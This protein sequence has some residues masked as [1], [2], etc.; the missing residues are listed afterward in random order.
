MQ[1]P[2]PDPDTLF[3]EILQDLPPETERMAREFKAFTRT[4]KIKTPA[5]LLR[6][7]LLY[8]GLDKSL[9]EVAGN[10]TLL[11]ER[12]TDS[13]VAE[14]LAACRPWLKALLPRMLDRPD[15]SSLPEGQRFLV[16]DGS[17]IQ[18]P[19][20]QGTQ[21]HLHL[22]MDL[23]TLEFTHI[24]ITDKRTGE[25]LKNFP[26]GP[27]DVGVADRGYA[28]P[29]AIVE[30]VSAGADLIVRLNPHSV[31]LFHRDG[32]PLDLV[33][34]LKDQ[35]HATVCTLPV[36]VGPSSSLD[37]V[38]G[39]VHAYRLSEEQANKARQACRKRNKRGEARR[40]PPCFWPVGF[41]CLPPFLQNSS[42][43]RQ[44]WMC[45]V[46]GGR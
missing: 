36:L 46:S 41:W 35:L 31:P 17:C 11:E 40:R 21:Y 10:L 1:S 23:V 32:S 43:R 27:G 5:Q 14:R 13:S 24:A 33:D 29:G 39:W 7:V 8:S 44:S 34:A 30:T 19:G 18:S 26:L 42:H 25:S 3:E 38:Q 6:A 4:R 22:C 16:I 45:T 37:R 20:A 2:P 28:H 12:I 9:R 15:L